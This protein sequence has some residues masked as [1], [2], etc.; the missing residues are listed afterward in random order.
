[1][2]LSKKNFSE[3][4]QTVLEEAEVADQRYNVKGFT[5][6]RPVSAFAEKRMYNMLEEELEK[7]GHKPTIF[8]SVIPGE[9]FELEKEHVEGFKAGVF[10]ITHAGDN[11][12]EKKLALRP[13]S[14]TAMYKMY[15]LW[16][17]SWRD[18]PLKIY[19]SCQIWRYETKATKPF[20]RDREFWWIEAHDVFGTE[21]EAH[22]QV[23]EDMEITENVYHKQWAIPF[24]F[25][26]RP[27]W[28]KFP[29]AVH[30]FAADTIMPDG[31]SIQIA[32]THLLGQNFAKPFHVTFHDKNE[33]EHYAWQTCFGPSIS[34]T[35][36]VLLSIH[37]DDKGL[38]LPFA[39]ASV[40][41]A[42]VPI[43]DKGSK[44][45]VLRKCKE[46]KKELAMFRTV[47]DDSDDKPGS[48]FY[49]WELRGVPIRLE[50]G[51]REVK[52]D[53]VT[54]VRRDTGKKEE[55][56]VKG[57]EQ[58][59]IAAADHILENLKKKAGE[60]LQNSIQKAHS[61]KEIKEKLVNGGLVRI[62]FCSIEK[63]GYKCAETIEKEVGASVLGVLHGK[64]EKPSGK[65][66]ACGK[67]ANEVVYI[68]R[69]Y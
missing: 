60:N 39:L 62:D 67:K 47:I 51:E 54:L 42:I 49:Y 48:K 4:Y 31:K 40:Q 28:D 19:Q 17:R 18:L 29:G 69:S 23:L 32:T 3:W 65:C 56:K 1:M 38:I 21:K 59:I 34:R 46:L 33:K 53:S 13:T 26:K 5:V 22:D 45:S 50:I 43:I 2:E 58:H 35:F 37:G 14:E 64:N 24:L 7:K 68:A 63:E 10:W 57:L 61:V 41:I 11:A 30:T 9:N 55:V 25:F 20:I 8:P 66:V 44:E 15:S 16:I 12:L 36:G 6:H 27:E 52:N